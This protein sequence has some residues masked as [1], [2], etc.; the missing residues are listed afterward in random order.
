MVQVRPP[1]HLSIGVLR[2]AP[3]KKPASYEIKNLKTA[4]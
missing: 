1:G 3:L 4:T 2:V